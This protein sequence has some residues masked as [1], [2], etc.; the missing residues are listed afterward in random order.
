MV[1]GVVQVPPDSTGKKIDTSELTR[2]D[3]TLVERQR[4][5]LGDAMNESSLGSVGVDG[6]QSVLENFAHLHLLELRRIARILEIM[7][8][9][10]V[11]I[12]DIE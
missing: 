9:V 4:V 3:G 11:S 6:R 7:A 10:N 1:D 2:N 8:G 12:S 5:T